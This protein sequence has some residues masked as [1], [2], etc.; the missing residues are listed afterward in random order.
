MSY[1]TILVHLNDER[2][3]GPLIDAARFLGDRDEA[4]VVGLY[5]MPIVSYGSPTQLGLSVIEAGRR[6]FREEAER[7][8]AAFE[9]AMKGS[10][11]TTEWRLV[12]SRSGYRDCA[13]LAVEQARTA[14]LVIASQS[15]PE[16]EYASMLEYP[17]RLA[18]ES[19]RPTL[20]VPTAGRFPTFGSRIVVAW[21]G[22]REAARAVFDALPVL[23]RASAVQIL[24]IKRRAPSR[25]E[26]STIE[27]VDIAASLGRHGVKCE[28]ATSIAPDIAIEDD[29]L[30]RAADFSADL[31]VMG[32]YGH[33]RL[34]E[35]VLGGASRAI[36]RTMTAPVLM[37]H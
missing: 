6:S 18:V 23:Q 7:I 1:K 35:F 36:F 30:S 11:L 33:S 5:V 29:L 13:S 12:E 17:E 15:D 19:G 34:R 2:R 24:T 21:N 25:S 20:L 14:D 31:I 8:K 37:A 32:C 3:V 22:S 4:H 28:V 27:A 10:A 26:E 16:W 9:A